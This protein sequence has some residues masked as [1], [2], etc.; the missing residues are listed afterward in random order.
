MSADAD[1][2]RTL[3]RHVI[4][5]LEPE[6]QREGY[7]LLDVRVFRGGGSLQVRLFVDLA[8]GGITLDDVAAASRTAGNLLEEADAIAGQYVLEVSSPGIRRPLRTPAHFA[9]AAG[10]RA[11]LKIEAEGRPRRLRGTVVGLQGR[12]LTFAPLAPAAPEGAQ[13]QAPE[14]APILLDLDGILEANLDPEFDAQALIQQDRRRRK[15]DRR[16]EKAARAK[17]RRKR[18]RKHGGA[19]DA[20]PQP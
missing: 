19:G 17:P 15:D 9:A 4:D 7:E 5:L 13:D 20:E 2:N 1:Q 11:D 6:L 3:A 10:Q 8:Q 12:T 16:S 18:V 14:P